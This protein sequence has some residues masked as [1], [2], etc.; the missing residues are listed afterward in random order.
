MPFWT[1]DWTG[2]DFEALDEIHSD[3]WRKASVMSKGGKLY[4]ATFINDKT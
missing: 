3:V 4:Y 2:P 1:K